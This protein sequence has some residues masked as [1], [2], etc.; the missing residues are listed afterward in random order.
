MN[1]KTELQ[2]EASA[3]EGL[4]STAGATLLRF[5]K[6][7]MLAKIKIF[8]IVKKEEL[9]HPIEGS[10]WKLKNETPWPKESDPVISVLDAHS[11]WVRY[12]IGG[13]VFQDE[14]LRLDSFL[15]CYQQI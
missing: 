1:D 2:S 12:K 7:W 13:G 3:K 14:R 8:K 9:V 10:Q 5:V 6:L 15:H 4:S 11:G